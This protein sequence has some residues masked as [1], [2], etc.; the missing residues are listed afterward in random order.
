MSPRDS[1]RLGS[2]SPT[3][4]IALNCRSFSLPPF[5][6][7]VCIMPYLSLDQLLASPL[8]ETTT[9]DPATLDFS[10]ST[11][12]SVGENVSLNNTTTLRKLYHYEPGATVHYPKT[13]NCPDLPI[14]HL[15]T[16]TSASDVYSPSKDFAYSLGAPW[17]SHK[18]VYVSLLTDSSNNQVPC[19]RLSATCNYKPITVQSF[20]DIHSTGQGLKICPFI[21]HTNSHTHASPNALHK[22]LMRD[23]SLLAEPT[24]EHIY[25]QKTLSL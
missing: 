1:H 9:L 17:G 16:M 7:T 12:V 19:E 13:S 22:Q 23:R 18:P 24:P 3:C 5:N 21:E 4:I 11:P 8:Q 20:S 10:D 2:L 6:L 14:G 25:F 15:F